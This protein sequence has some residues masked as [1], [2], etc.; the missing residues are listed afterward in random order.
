VIIGK[1][2]NLNTDNRNV[3]LSAVFVRFVLKGIKITWLVGIPVLIVECI[4]T[5]VLIALRIFMS[6]CQRILNDD[7]L[8]IRYQE[9][10]GEA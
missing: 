4:F 3:M 9:T 10:R 7:P 5:F 6:F 8:T 1:V 2:R